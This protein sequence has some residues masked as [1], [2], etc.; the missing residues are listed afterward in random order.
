MCSGEQVAKATNKAIK[1]NTPMKRIL[2]FLLTNCLEDQQ[3]LY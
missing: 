1:N 2:F 3:K